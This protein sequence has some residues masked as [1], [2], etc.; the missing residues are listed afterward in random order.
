MNSLTILLVDDDEMVR[1]TIARV[2]RDGGHVVLEATSVTEAMDVDAVYGPVHLI[3]HDVD[4]G[5]GGRLDDATVNYYE[6]KGVP[7]IAFT[8]DVF[9]APKAAKRVVSKGQIGTL[10]D[11]IRTLH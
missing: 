9:T 7:L 2:L 3:I 11:A 6:G 4:L 10:L 8:G 1:D 5:D